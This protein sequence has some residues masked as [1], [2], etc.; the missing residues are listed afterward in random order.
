MRT[1][2]QLSEQGLV[3][4]RA[5]EE[6]RRTKRIFLTRKALPLIE[7]IDAIAEQ[8][9]VEMLEGL[10]AEQVDQFC[11]CLMVMEKNGLEIA[12]KVPENA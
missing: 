6:D 4:R 7:K 12:E 11:E 1:L 10:S 5:C 9:R 3:E 8:T 2:D